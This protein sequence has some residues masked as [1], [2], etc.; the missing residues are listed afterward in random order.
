MDKKEVKMI[1]KIIEWLKVNYLIII[2]VILVLFLLT[3]IQ[4]PI[5][6]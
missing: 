4:V 6:P 5:K 2:V 3:R 1:K